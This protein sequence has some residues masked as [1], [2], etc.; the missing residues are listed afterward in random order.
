MASGFTLGTAFVEIQTTGLTKLQRDISKIGTDF[1]RIPTLK[2]LN[3]DIRNTTRSMDHFGKSLG[4]AGNLLAVMPGRGASGMSTLSGAIG[5]AS[6]AMGGLTLAAGG[7]TA[8]IAALAATGATLVKSV[9]VAADLETRLAEVATIS[10]EV[11]G[12]M[13]GFANEIGK[14]SISTRTQSGL[15]AEGLYQTISSGITD[16]AEALK[17]LEVS[18]NASR[19][20]L[21]N[22]GTAVSG[23]TSAL[24]AYGLQASDAT[25]V[26]DKFFT[27]VRAGKLRFEDIASSIGSV[28]P[29]ASQLNISLD[30]LLA[31]G[32]ALTLTGQS[33]SASF[34][35]IQG[36]MN[37]VLRPTK[38]AVELAAELGLEFSATA[39]RTKG[40]TQFLKDLETQ[41][42]GDVEIMGQLFGRIEGLRGVLAL[43]GNQADD[44][45]RILGDVQNASG[46]TEK[47]VDI[48][49]QTFQAQV[50]LLKNQL[51]ETLRII[52]GELL[53]DVTSAL[54][55]M[56]EALM[57]VDWEGFTNGVKEAISFV[58]NFANVAFQTGKIVTK[59]FAFGATKDVRVLAGLLPESKAERPSGLTVPLP[60]P[61]GS[62]TSTTPA[63]ALTTAAQTT[64]ASSLS[65]AIALD[66]SGQ[67]IIGGIQQQ[68][69]GQRT[70]LLPSQRALRPLGTTGGFVA[71]QGVTTGTNIAGTTRSPIPG[72]SGQLVSPALGIKG[73]TP[74]SVAPT[75][76]KLGALEFPTTLPN[77]LKTFADA[78]GEMPSILKP[79]TEELGVALGQDLTPILKAEGARLAEGFSLVGSAIE[80]GAAGGLPGAL[81]AVGTEL[82]SMT[83]GFGRI[84]ESFNNVV[85][86]LVMA[87]DPVVS[88]LADVL[89]PVFS[90]LGDV[91][92]ELTPLFK[93]TGFV[94]KTYFGPGLSLVSKLLGALASAIRFVVNGF[95]SIVN[96]I[97]NLINKV[98]G[99]DIKKVN[100]VG[101]PQEQPPN[102]A[103][104]QEP[105]GAAATTR[106][107]RNTTRGIQVSR[108]TGQTRDV[109]VELLKPLR[110]L[111]IFP[112]ML[113]ELKNIRTVLTPGYRI[114]SQSA[115]PN[116][117][118]LGNFAARQEFQANANITGGTAENARGGVVINNPV[119]Q[120]HVN[121]VTDVDIELLERQLQERL[122]L[123]RRGA[124]EVF[125]VRA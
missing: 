22:V 120:I 62:R 55:S 44:F 43:T 11:A 87:I 97:I 3:T 109:F 71:P 34:T 99:I 28:A 75:G 84:Q 2:G 6:T 100:K 122:N 114:P 13:K 42:G 82:L 7:A 65:R 101:A 70:A 116:T 46:A 119:F 102:E 90:A 29:L 78:V 121:Q 106:G 67:N 81:I 88:A 38:Q 45:A 36:V 76:E 108:I 58:K 85:G 25:S 80:G 53:P 115:V 64:V 52:G 50:D 16:A 89:E 105:T 47:A 57:Q 19:A 18:A 10:E 117:P 83:E 104:I 8:G 41:A 30:E 63:Q 37:A 32:A 96:G 31:S 60:P 91:F 123:N 95:I 111:D 73:P 86:K 1:K 17:V 27:T 77:D 24:N 98:P 59:L 12:N 68:R 23:V 112:A 107:T 113:D 66:K 74:A 94:L 124:G 51:S 54:K 49:N 20:G 72:V 26:S 69:P 56:N 15:L 93:T 33:L 118:A 110:N 21:T 48:Q 40:L 39:L 61:P 5:T 103:G 125:P 35:N 92:K 9:Q 79:A 4:T 14:L